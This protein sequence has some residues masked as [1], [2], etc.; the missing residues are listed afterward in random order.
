LIVYHDQHYGFDFSFS[1]GII[2]LCGC[3]LHS[4]KI[5]EKMF[6]C[7]LSTEYCLCLN[8]IYTDESPLNE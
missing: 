6:P 5:L 7:Y 4:L 3:G 8:Y 2:L 1:V